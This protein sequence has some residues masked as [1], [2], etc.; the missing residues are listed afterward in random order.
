MQQ[1]N[2]YSTY[3]TIFLN[4]YFSYVMRIHEIIPYI[5]VVC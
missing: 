5:T 4:K 3:E 2:D 1:I